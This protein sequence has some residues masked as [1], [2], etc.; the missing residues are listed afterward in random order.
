MF[1]IGFVL[2]A[3]LLAG[4]QGKSEDVAGKAASIADFN[5]PE[6]YQPEMALS[7]AGYTIVSYNPGDGQGH[8]YLIQAPASQDV[9][10]E[11]LEEQLSGVKVGQKDHYSRQTV[12]ETRP[13]TIRGQET[14]LVISEGT[15]GEGDSY[16]QLTTAFQGK[17]GLALLVLEEPVDRWDNQRVDELVA[18]IK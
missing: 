10:P 14:T 8:L 15:N 11:K 18:S 6:G 3:A 4:C 7:L 17:G 12:V 2:V 1:M 16:R 13:V 5:V 9:T